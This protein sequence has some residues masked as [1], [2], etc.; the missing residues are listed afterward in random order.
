[1]KGVIGLTGGIASGKSTVTAYLREKGYWVLDADALVHDLQKKG[2][3]LYQLLV[4]EFGEEILRRD[5]ELDRQALGQAVFAD[6]ALRARLSRLQDDV[7]RQAIVRERDQALASHDL[8]FLDIPLLYEA[9]Y[10][11]EVDAV[12][13]VV[14]PRDLQLSRLRQRNGYSLTEAQQRLAAQLPLEEKKALATAIIDNSGTRQATYA[15][16]DALLEKRLDKKS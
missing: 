9:G 13:L 6:P 1:M 5:G 15:Q 8:V 10:E 16:I 11:Q 4:A 7:I 14:V 3:R 2:G 12:W